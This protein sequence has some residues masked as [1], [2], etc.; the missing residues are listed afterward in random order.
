METL[1]E[2]VRTIALAAVGSSGAVGLIFYFFK[3]WIDNKFSAA[4]IE[5]EKKRK[6]KEERLEVDEELHHTYGR[7]F[8]WLHYA[9]TKN[10]ANGELEEAFE[11]LQRAEEK[12]KKLDRR[13]IAEI[14][15]D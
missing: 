5:A 6:I 8:F 15:K 2:I 9:V 14:E 7:M 11:A 3:K 4:E 10:V 1:E 12:K 13:S